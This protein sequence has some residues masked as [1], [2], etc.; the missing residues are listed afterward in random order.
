MTARV[1]HYRIQHRLEPSEVGEG[2]LARDDAH[3][4]TVVL[5]FINRDR[6]PDGERR[7]RFIRGAREAAAITHPHVSRNYEVHEIDDQAV[8]VMEHVQ[9]QTVQERVAAGAVEPREVIWLGRELAQALAAMHTRGILCRD[10]TAASIALTGEGHVKLLDCGLAH[11]LE[12]AGGNEA[13]SMPRGD[14]P[15][16]AAMPGMPVYLA[17]EVLKGGEPTSRSD[18]YAAGVVLYVMTT[19][20][21]PFAERATEASLAEMLLHPPVPPSLLVPGVPLALERAVMRLLEKKPEAR[22]PSAESLAAAL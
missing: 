5:R 11:L 10:L 13:V 4:R 1:G 7:R 16:R 15:S 14:V 18:L 19:A 9:G 12:A 3:H 6:L 2:Y 21:L 8:L 22:F 20:R 17:P